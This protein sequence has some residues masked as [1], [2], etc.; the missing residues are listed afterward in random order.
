MF[1]LSVMPIKK[2]GKK[3]NDRVT[4][5]ESI[6]FTVKDR[7]CSLK[8]ACTCTLKAAPLEKKFTHQGG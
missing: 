3:G 5:P 1:P 2:G 4:P 8:S 7:F 6:P